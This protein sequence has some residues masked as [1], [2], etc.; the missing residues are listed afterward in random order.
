MGS[1]NHQE[2]IDKTK[3]IIKCIEMAMGKAVSSLD[4]EDTIRE[5]GVSLSDKPKPTGG[6][7]F[8]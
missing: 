7:L 8:E 3:Q 6:S 5:F 4:T 1:L 2:V